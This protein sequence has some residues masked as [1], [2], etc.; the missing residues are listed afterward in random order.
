[1]IT[2][3]LPHPGPLPL[4]GQ[5]LSSVL[6]PARACSLSSHLSGKELFPHR[7]VPLAMEGGC[8]EGV[9]SWPEQWVRDVPQFVVVRGGGDLRMPFPAREAGE[10]GDGA[11]GAQAPAGGS[12]IIGD[13]PQPCPCDLG[14]GALSHHA[15]VSPSVKWRMT[16]T[17]VP[18]GR[19][20]ITQSSL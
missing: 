9:A 2:E 5:R 15:S 12:G 10:C 11:G 19:C 8:R 14:L 20:E 1:M 6:G 17:S 16:T 4:K 13:A 3:E 7:P 18:Q